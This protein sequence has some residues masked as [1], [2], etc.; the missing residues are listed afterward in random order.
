MNLPIEIRKRKLRNGIIEMTAQFKVEA[1]TK[2]TDAEKEMESFIK[3]KMKH[4][5]EKA[6][7][8]FLF[9]ELMGGATTKLVC[10]KTMVDCNIFVS[11]L[12]PKVPVVPE[13][14]YAEKELELET[15]WVTIM[16]LHPEIFAKLLQE[17]IPYIRFKKTP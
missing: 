2:F 15:E 1:K 3:D 17:N 14:A 5:I 8:S 16:I 7:L 13:F 10:G 12:V 6:L 4:R 9:K 11:S